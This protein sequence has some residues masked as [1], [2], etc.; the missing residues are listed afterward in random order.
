MLTA[1]SEPPGT[2]SATA[3]LSA[4][5]PAGILTE[6]R[7]EKVSLR[8]ESATMLEP[9]PA[10]RATCAS[11]TTSGPRP[12]SFESRTRSRLPARLVCTIW[13]SVWSWNSEATSAHR[14]FGGPVGAVAQVPT[15]DVGG[16]PRCAARR[17]ASPAGWAIA[18][19]IRHS[20]MAV[21][22]RKNFRLMTEPPAGATPRAGALDY[23][24]SGV[25][26]APHR[27]IVTRR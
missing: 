24:P 4:G 21:D 11:P 25:N 16:E 12:N 14:P 9:L 17:S 18:A 5:A 7:P 10:R 19:N 22:T 6:A 23:R 3:S 13:R 27:V 2:S 1:R 20:D 26:V 8:S 15:H